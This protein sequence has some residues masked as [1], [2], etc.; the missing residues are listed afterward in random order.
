MSIGRKRKLRVAITYIAYPVAMG[1]YFHEAL[2]DDP[3]IEVWSTGPF[4]GQ[5]IPW[6][7][8]MNLPSEYVL[9]PSHPTPLTNP[10][11][12]S[13]PMLE[14]EKPWEPDLWIEVNAGLTAL[15]KPTSAPLAMVLTD[16]HVLTDFYRDQRPR[17]D[18]VFNMQTPY[19]QAGDIWLPYGYSKRWHTPTQI[20]FIDRKYDAAL[21]GLQYDTRSRLV[22]SLRSKNLQVYY[23]LG[24]AYDDA[25]KIYHDTR[26]GLNWSSLQDTTARCFELMALG[27]PAVMNRVP[28]LI[29]MFR[30]GE[31]FLGFSTLDEAVKAVKF[32]LANP[33]AAAKIAANGLKAVEKH[34]WDNRIQ[35]ILEKVGLD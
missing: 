25:R 8:G 4:T 15:G 14:R 13:Y 23:H 1:R 31:D 19:M 9:K 32:L 6:N 33:E 7:G 3:R 11:M 10:P 35:T 24:P 30:D 27:L 20:P 17:A 34:S 28:D 2:L 18:F 29:T 26:V 21:M 12:I 16:P 22:A 5:W